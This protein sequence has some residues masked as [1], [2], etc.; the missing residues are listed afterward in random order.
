MKHDTD[1]LSSALT[2]TRCLLHRSEMSWTLVHKQLQTRPA[3]YPP[4]VNSASCFIARLRRRR[5]ANGTQPHFAKRWMVNGANNLP[6]KSWG[7][8]AGKKLGANFY[9]CSVF[10]QLGYLMANIC[11]KTVT[12]TIGQRRLK[13]WRSPI[14]SQNFINFGPQMA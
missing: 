6:Q 10:R 8:Y 3:F 13:V 9:I 2:T 7:R 4:S 14:L 5:S 12:W 1:N 11:W